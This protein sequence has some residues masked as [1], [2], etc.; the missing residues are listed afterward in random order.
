MMYSYQVHLTTSSSS[1]AVYDGLGGPP[2]DVFWKTLSTMLT[3]RLV[4]I[5]ESKSGTKTFCWSWYT[6]PL[7][8]DTVVP[9]LA[10][11]NK[12]FLLS[13]LYFSPSLSTSRPPTTEGAYSKF[14]TRA[15]H[16][17]ASIPILAAHNKNL[18]LRHPAARSS[19]I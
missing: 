3:L 12:V 15:C 2:G 16:L 10:I 8:F 17:V 11:T 14:R 4:R 1:A 18:M 9:R 5:E 7:V 6:L 13:S 19:Q